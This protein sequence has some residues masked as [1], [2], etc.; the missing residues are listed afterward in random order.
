MKINQQ[1]NYDAE[2]SKIFEDNDASDE[3]Y[4]EYFYSSHMFN[5]KQDNGKYPN[6]IRELTKHFMSSG[7]NN[8]ISLIS[9]VCLL[10]SL[11][12][13]FKVEALTYRPGDKNIRKV[14]YPLNLYYVLSGKANKG[15]STLLDKMF[16]IYLK[17]SPL[18]DNV[19]SAKSS[20]MGLFKNTSA[21]WNYMLINGDDADWILNPELRE[22]SVIEAMLKLWNRKYLERISQSKELTEPKETRLTAWIGLH[23]FENLNKEQISNGFMRRL[24]V[25]TFEDFEE[26]EE[27]KYS[28]ELNIGK[29]KKN[30]NKE[31]PYDLIMKFRKFIAEVIKPEQ[32]RED[33]ENLKIFLINDDIERYIRKVFDR[34]ENYVKT[35]PE[36]LSSIIRTYPEILQRFVSIYSL[37]DGETVQYEDGELKH[38]GR[39][40]LLEQVEHIDEIL[41][42]NLVY[43]YDD[44]ERVKFNKI[45]F[46]VEDMSDN[47][48][49]FIEF[50]RKN[51]I[52]SGKDWFCSIWKLKHNYSYDILKIKKIIETGVNNNSFKLF[53]GKGNNNKKSYYLASNTEGLVSLLKKNNITE[54]K[55]IPSNLIMIINL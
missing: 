31:L 16:D 39:A 14:Y 54:A 9:S 28:D 45:N 23:G 18:K 44:L 51:G 29:T 21:D 24:L 3:D 26:K 10:S 47:I 49:E 36:H 20:S 12:P 1:D 30:L 15:K 38:L 19:V 33:F 43:Y 34:I 53:T 6:F 2:F 46:H 55:I 32:R 48:K 37:W 8:D 52:N 13:D 41:W 11:T 7:Y 50:S 5:K 42:R 35:K 17:I 4:D 40:I 25:Y 27:I 22:G